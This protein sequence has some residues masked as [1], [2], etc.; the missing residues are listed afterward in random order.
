MKYNFLLILLV[1]LTGCGLKKVENKYANG[2][3]QESFTV[4]DKGEKEGKY[5]SFTEDGKLY[6]ESTYKND[7]LIGKRTLFFSNGKPEIEEIYIEGGII[8]GPYKSYYEN[9]NIK[10]EKTFENNTLT[11][12]TKVYYPSGKI[13]EEVTMSN[14]QENGPFTEYYENGQIHW[15]GSYLDGDNEFGLLEE[16]DSLGVMI[17]RMKC[18]SMAICRTFW[19]PGMPAVNYDTLKTLPPLKF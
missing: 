6:E 10:I 19:R 3:V 8:H 12:L 18:D 15:K 4:N 11:G 7:K 9:G 13:K 17:K 2:H 1:Y 14:N 16:W 5:Q